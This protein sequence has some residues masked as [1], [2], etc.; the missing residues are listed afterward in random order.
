MQKESNTQPDLKKGEI[1][2]DLFI[3]DNQKIS[4]KLWK[5][6]LI[7]D[8]WRFANVVAKRGNSVQKIRGV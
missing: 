6:Y 2:H 7:D 1:N 5:P 8:V 4:E 3:I